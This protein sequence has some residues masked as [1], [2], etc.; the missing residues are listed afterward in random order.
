MNINKINANEKMPP[1]RMKQST[2]HIGVYFDTFNNSSFPNMALNFSTAKV[3]SY[4]E[5][6][7]AGTV[8][9][10]LVRGTSTTIGNGE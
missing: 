3:P 10:A 6:F 7:N 5:N 8:G 1:T 2:D 4:G 9:N